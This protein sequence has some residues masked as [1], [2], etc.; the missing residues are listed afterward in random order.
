MWVY[1]NVPE[2]QYLEYMASPKQDQG[3]RKVE[4]VLANG[5]KFP[6]SGKI[7]V[8]GAQFNNQTGNIAFRADFPNPDGLLRH[9]QAGAIMIHRTLHDAI[10]IPQR[11]TYRFSISGTFTSS[12]KMT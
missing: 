7:G 3:D 4:L 6:R 11:A 10:I 12:A 1:F 9:G 8:I 5:N 2:A